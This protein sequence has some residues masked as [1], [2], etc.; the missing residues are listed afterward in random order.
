MTVLKPCNFIKK[1]PTLCFSVNIPKVSGTA[2]IIEKLVVPFELSFS[3]RK[4]FLKKEVSGE[5]TFALINLLHVKMQEP[6][7]R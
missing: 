4:E 3:I 5:I 6:P 2:L 7:T 1:T